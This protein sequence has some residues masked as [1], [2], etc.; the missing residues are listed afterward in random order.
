[1]DI[2]YNDDKAKT[3]TATYTA[4][5]EG[6][7][8]VK[9]EFAGKQVPKSPFPVKVEGYA[10]DPSK[11]KA[12]GPGLKPTGVSAGVPTHFDV[13]SKGELAG[14]VLAVTR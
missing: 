1:M 6:P 13:F 12:S 5:K 9:V 8:K 3:Y 14:H 11:V 4:K 2:R 10:G 7:H